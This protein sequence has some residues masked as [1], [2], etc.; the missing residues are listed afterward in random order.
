MSNNSAINF[1]EATLASAAKALAIMVERFVPE[2]NSCFYSATDICDCLQ[3]LQFGNSL[4][5]YADIDSLKLGLMIRSF[6]TALSEAFPGRFLFDR[7]Q[8]SHSNIS[9]GS[10]KFKYGFMIK[11][12]TRSPLSVARYKNKLISDVT[13]L[14]ASLLLHATSLLEL[15][16]PLVVTR[17]SPA[18]VNAIPLLLQSCSAV[19]FPQDLIDDKNKKLKKLRSSLSYFRNN[20]TINEKPKLN[21]ET[22]EKSIGDKLLDLITEANVLTEVINGKPTLSIVTGL[23]VQDLISNCGCSMNKIPMIISTVVT[24]LFGL[25]ATDA[26]RSIVR[27]PDTYSLASER[28]AQLVVMNGRR[29]F[30]NRDDPD[31]ILNAFLILDASNKKN[32]GLVAKPINYV[33]KDGVVRLGALKMDNTGEYR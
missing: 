29:R 21:I 33:S 23:L 32:K 28:A 22:S 16:P 3:G 20:N 11:F 30:I 19:P 5:L 6:R 17:N 1:S 12:I 10:N 7:S 8:S 15:N 2:S 27:A 24:M 4:A 18:K 26:F 25:V 9:K 13:A 31:A 14:S